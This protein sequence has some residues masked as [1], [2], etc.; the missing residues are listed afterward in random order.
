MTLADGAACVRQ[1]GP[2]VNDDGDHVTYNCVGGGV[3]VGP[4]QRS[5]TWWALESTDNMQTFMDV[6]IASVTY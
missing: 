2:Q 4:L 1:P 5:T 3:L 6:R